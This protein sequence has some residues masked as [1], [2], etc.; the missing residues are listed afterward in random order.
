MT[1]RPSQKTVFLSELQHR[2]THGRNNLLQG[3]G[4]CLVDESVLEK[5]MHQRPVCS[6]YEI[7]AKYL[8]F[9][10][11][12][13]DGVAIGS[14]EARRKT[15]RAI[16]DRF[17]IS[18]RVISGEKIPRTTIIKSFVDDIVGLF[19]D[20]Y[21]RPVLENMVLGVGG[22]IIRLNEQSAIMLNE[23]TVLEVL[24]SNNSESSVI[25]HMIKIADS[26]ARSK[27]TNGDVL[28]CRNCKKG[29]GQAW[30]QKYPGSSIHDW[31][32]DNP[33][34]VV[35]D[36]P[37]HTDDWGSVGPEPKGFKDIIKALA[38][39]AEKVENVFPGNKKE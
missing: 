34:F 15:E 19:R 24:L 35:H 12:Y 38:D 23:R 27:L 4:R 3:R 39:A 29:K 2:I 20:S 17:M 26:F 5:P 16:S 9:A 31:E 25:S 13:E 1:N 22:N 30:K 33:G 14:T 32:Q 21:Q 6:V 7:L 11:V 8:S 18:S 37:A 10:A 36:G 28:S